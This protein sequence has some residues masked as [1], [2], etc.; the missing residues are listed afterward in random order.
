[1]ESKIAIVCNL[2]QSGCN[3]CC[4]LG[5]ASSNYL[6]LIDLPKSVIHLNPCYR[7]LTHNRLSTDKK[8]QR[9]LYHEQTFQRYSPRMAKSSYQ[10]SIINIKWH[11]ELFRC[12][13]EV[14]TMEVMQQMP[15]PLSSPSS[16]Y[17]CMLLNINS[18]AK[19]PEHLSLPPIVVMTPHYDPK[20]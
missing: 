18:N 8:M 14:H 15:T 19:V 10:W 4:W 16:P 12:Q 20:T 1:M 5:P 17:V 7:E 3:F 6:L 13:G 2:N 9:T 11:A